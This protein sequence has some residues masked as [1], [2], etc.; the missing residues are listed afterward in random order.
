MNEEFDFDRYWLEKLSANLEV[1]LDPSDAS[2]VM[3]GSEV[4]THHTQRADVIEWTN[5]AMDRLV[6]HTTEEQ[7]KQIMLDCACQYPA[8]ELE[9]IREHYAQTRDIATTIEM[10]QSLFEQFL[11]EGLGMDDAGIE[12]IREMGWGL[13]GIR[14]GQS[15]IA[16]KIPKSAYLIEYL[17]SSDPGKRREIY[18]H[19]PRVREAVELG[20]SIPTIHCF[21]G[22][23]F[24]KGL[25]EEVL[26]QRVEVEVL[27]TVLS[28]GEVCRFRIHLPF[29]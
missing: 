18:C 10:L 20:A 23:G 12:Q 17:A 29:E 2:D 1:V 27:E 8:A 28:G 15:I 16:T 22:A 4:I 26:Q 19:C 21:C 24:Y 9:P 25:W 3:Q 6:V 14:D 11:Q 13:A 5:G 7:R